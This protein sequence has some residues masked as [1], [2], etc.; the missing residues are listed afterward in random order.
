MFL[1]EYEKNE[2][3]KI[4]IDT[5]LTLVTEELE[6]THEQK[7]KSI[8]TEITQIKKEQKKLLLDIETLEEKIPEAIRGDYYF[9]IE[10][11]SEMVK[12]KQAKVEEL[13]ELEKEKKKQLK[14]MD[15]EK[16]D[17]QQFVKV[18][19]NWSM[20]FMNADTATK[21]MLLASVIDKIIVKNDD[22]TIKFKISLDNFKTDT[23]T[24]KTEV[25]L[26]NMETSG[27][28]LLLEKVH[29]PT[30]LYILCLK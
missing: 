25:A 8:N 27:D 14:I 4:E 2:K 19:P 26:E 10:K 18:V 21:K 16:A 29:H 5:K 13:K 28:N 7:C 15:V 3:N 9:S 30:T 22:I 20:E 17:L 11:L 23:N 12:D 24:E 6:K 1:L